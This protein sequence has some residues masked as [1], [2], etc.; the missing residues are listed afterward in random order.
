MATTNEKKN[1]YVQKNSS[2][3]AAVGLAIAA[4][5]AQATDF[6][7]GPFA[8]KFD[9]T[10]SLGAIWRTGSRDLR[11]LHPGN[12]EGGRGQSGVADDGNLNFDR[13]DLTSLVFKGVSRP[14]H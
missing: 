6:E 7:V 14:R 8:V 10:F 2:L 3:A 9:S 5:P 11:V 1:N 12:Y 13:G 4:A